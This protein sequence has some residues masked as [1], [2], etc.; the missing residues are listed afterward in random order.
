MLSTNPLPYTPSNTYYK[1][2]L[3][4]PYWV[5]QENAKPL[6]DHE[7]DFVYQQN[8]RYFFNSDEV[9]TN[10]FI[11][12]NMSTINAFGQTKRHY[13]SV[14]S[15][16][17]E[18]YF[19]KSRVQNYLV[20]KSNAEPLSDEAYSRYLSSSKMGHDKKFYLDKKEVISSDT[21]KNSIKNAFAL[22]YEEV[23]NSVRIATNKKHAAKLLGLEDEFLLDLYL[24]EK[25]QTDFVKLKLEIFQYIESL[26][27]DAI[28]D[29]ESTASTANSQDINP[30]LPAVAN[31]ETSSDQLLNLDDL[32][33]LDT[34]DIP[35]KAVEPSQP[36]RRNPDEDLEALLN[37]NNAD[38]LALGLFKKP[39]LALE[40]LDKLFLDEEDVRLD[41][42]LKKT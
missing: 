38:T 4:K 21:I 42:K 9:C 22:P 39:R 20:Y 40:E 41:K 19:H 13:V 31:A 18:S 2:L 12:Q 32:L 3:D 17:R 8:G 1:T 30:I 15:N 37:E 28:T 35:E 10:E 29:V 16:Q 27:I 34:I 5:Y 11:Q 36:K 24:G 23:F 25:Y 6:A 7:Q 14:F 26:S 33:T